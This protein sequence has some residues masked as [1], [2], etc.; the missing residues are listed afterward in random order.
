MVERPKPPLAWYVGLAVS[1]FL[2]L[3]LGA[4]VMYLIT[5]GVGVWGVNQPSGWG[6]AIINFVWWVGIGHAGTLI[7]AILFLFRQQWR[8]SINRAAEA[9]T[10]TSAVL[11][12]AAHRRDDF[13]MTPRCR[14]GP[15]AGSVTRVEIRRCD[16]SRVSGART[17]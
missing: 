17:P 14:S 1:G 3:V 15:S 8:T 12:E 16:T 4:M 11:I 10:I 9:M 6:F 13:M 5:T 7:S 2:C